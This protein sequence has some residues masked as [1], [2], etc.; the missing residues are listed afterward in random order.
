MCA[1]FEIPQ[2]FQVTQREWNAALFDYGLDPAAFDQSLA[3][4]RLGETCALARLTC[5]ELLPA[6]MDAEQSMYLPR[7]DM[8][9]NS[10]GHALAAEALAS[11]GRHAKD[12]TPPDRH[13]CLA[14][15]LAA[16]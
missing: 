10:S 3:S 8:H 4:R 11:P 6:F 14:R 2:R 16:P 15:A 13:R 5:V 9:W 1:A 7:G 12:S